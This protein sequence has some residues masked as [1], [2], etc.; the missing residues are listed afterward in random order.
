MTVY[1]LSV[2]IQAILVVKTHQ[3]PIKISAEGGKGK[4]ERGN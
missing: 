4:F 1:L 2:T 3:N